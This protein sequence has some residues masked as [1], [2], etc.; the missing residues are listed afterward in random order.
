MRDHRTSL[1]SC[2]ACLQWD[3][4]KYS[5]LEATWMTESSRN[6]VQTCNSLHKITVLWHHFVT[7]NLDVD[8]PRV[9]WWIAWRRYADVAYAFIKYFLE[10]FQNNFLYCRSNEASFSILYYSTNGAHLALLSDT[11]W[12]TISLRFETLFVPVELLLEYLTRNSSVW[13]VRKHLY[14]TYVHKINACWNVSSMNSRMSDL[15]CC[16]M[17]SR[18]R[19][20]S[21][22]ELAP[23][24]V[25][26]MSLSIVVLSISKSLCI[27]QFIWNI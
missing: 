13:L 22:E 18:N 20:W 7:D 10:M 1:D 11:K 16:F 17:P 26:L 2:I 14:E 23:W 9:W 12:Q 3:V 24:L 8:C 19:M 21:V 25:A 5:P 6:Y 27:V 15:P 4:K